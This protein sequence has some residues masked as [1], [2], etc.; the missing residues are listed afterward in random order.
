MSGRSRERR[1]PPRRRRRPRRR[2]ACRAGGRAAASARRGRRRGRRRS[3]QS[4]AARPQSQLDRR[5]RAPGPSDVERPPASTR[6][7]AHPRQPE[8]GRGAPGREAVAVVGSRRTTV[9][10][11]A[12]LDVDAHV[13]RA[14]VAG[15]VRQRLLDDAV[16]DDLL[17][18][19]EVLERRRRRCSSS[20]SARRA[21]ELS[22]CVRS[23]A[24]S[25]WSSSAAG[26]S[27]RARRSSSLHRLRR[28]ALRLAQLGAQ[29]RRRVLGGGLEAQQ[30][31]AQ[32]LVG[33]VV[34][35]ARQ[36]RALGLLRRAAR[37]AAVARARP[38]G[39]RACG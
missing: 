29:R 20:T 13:A 16:D 3:A 28:D 17:V 14:G 12:A 23:A 22:T 31:A 25:P 36:A 24:P 5:A 38:P 9:P 11:V 8:P 34:Q 33:L 18:V 6:A 37:A 10:P 35:V 19:A 4:H 32:R 7:L 39:A 26:R 30:H 21:A 1:A 2:P 27:S 15:D